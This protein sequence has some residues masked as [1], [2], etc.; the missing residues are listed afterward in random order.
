MCDEDTCLYCDKFYYSDGDTC[1]K[2]DVDY[3]T[4]CIGSDICLDCVEGR[5]LDGNS[6]EL[7]SVDHC[8]VLG[9]YLTSCDQCDDGYYYEIF[10]DSCEKCDSSCKRCS[11][12]EDTDCTACTVDKISYYPDFYIGDMGDLGDLLGDYDSEL[13]EELAALED[14]LDELNDYL[15]GSLGDLFA[16]SFSC[17]SK[18]PST[19]D[20][21]EKVDEYDDFGPAYCAGGLD[22]N[23]TY[24]SDE[25]FSKTYGFYED[26]TRGSVLESAVINGIG[27]VLLALIAFFQF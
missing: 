19:N 24:T 14:E 17:V 27:F 11:G 5:S 18:C 26:D 7:L 8:A 22:G 6:C 12:S 13:A 16:P 23:A 1:E 9:N 3:C 21:G 25:V 2:C 4:E 15:G 10:T 20:L